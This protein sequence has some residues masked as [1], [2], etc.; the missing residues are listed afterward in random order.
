MRRKK[1]F[2]VLAL[3]FVAVAFA[4]DE[5]TDS[6]TRMVQGTV[7]AADSSPVDGAVVQLNDTRTLQIRSFVTKSDGTYHFAGLSTNHEYELQA[8]HNGAT[9][10]K[11]RLDVFD[12]HKVATINLKLNK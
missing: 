8:E 9:S 12:G 6:G 2:A 4:A 3:M 11:K 5:K 10:G 1:I 7:T